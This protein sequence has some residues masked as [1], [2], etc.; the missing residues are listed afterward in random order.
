MKI[1]LNFGGKYFLVKVQELLNFNHAISQL[2][3]FTASI[4]HPFQGP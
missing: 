2:F 4:S 3:T 1:I